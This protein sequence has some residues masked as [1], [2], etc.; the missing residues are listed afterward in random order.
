MGNI[1]SN[2]KADDSLPLSNGATDVLLSVFILA[3]SD[4]AQTDWQKEAIIWFAEHDQSIFGRGVVG[5][6]IDEIAWQ[7]DQFIEQQQFLLQVIDLALQRHH[8]DKLDYQPPHAHEY[9]IKLRELITSYTI[10]MI[11]TDKHWQWYQA[12]TEFIKCAK[13]NVYEHANGCLICHDN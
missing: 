1:I 9:L 11:E 13:H 7:K 12:P 6:D 8:W 4:L 3:G 5:F 10:E 2:D